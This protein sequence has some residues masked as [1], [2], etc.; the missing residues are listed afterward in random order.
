MSTIQARTKS[1]RQ[2]LDGIHYGIDYYQ[3]EYV[4]QRRHVEELLNDLAEKFED[5]YDSM[6]A[7]SQVAQY[8]HYFLGSIITVV[9]NGQHYI[10]D[11]QQRLTTLTLLFIYLHH[12]RQNNGAIRNLTQLIYA[13]KF[14]KKGFNIDVAARND[15]MQALFEAGNFDPT[16]QVDLSVRNLVDR[17]KDLQELFPETLAGPAAPY[18]VDWLIENVD[19]VEIVAQSDDDAFTIFESMNDRGVNLSQVDMLKGYLLAHINSDDARWAHQTKEKANTVWKKLTL[20]LADIEKDEE[21]TF[22]KVWLRAKYAD[23]IRQRKKGAT[24]QD[25]ENINTFHRWARDNRQRLGLY[26]TQDFYNFI[27]QK[28]RYFAE[29]YIAMRQAAQTFT[30]DREA[31]YYN[32]YNNFTLQY[33]LALAPLRL[34]DDKD[35]AQEKIR[36]VTTFADI[37]LARRMV[38]FR[39][40]GYNTLAYT[41]FNLMRDIRD[42]PVAELQAYLLDY[43]A[44]MKD[45]FKGITGDHY[46]AY[47]LNN[48]SG[49]SIRYLL[50]RITAW[51]EQKSGKHSNFLPLLTS[52]RANRSRLSISGRTTSSA[53]K[54]NSPAQPSSSATA[55]FLAG[56]SCCHAAPTK[57]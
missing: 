40:N 31:I 29:T 6:H 35:I 38:N 16:D 49:R 51:V 1:V 25:F 53:T 10:V 44:K 24:N 15:C 52:N 57:A 54:T 7:R 45:S 18:F 12:L 19:M 11:G 8:P 27:D 4:W 47:R 36:L 30:P 55:I 50:A 17:Y 56:C 46:E 37:F 22:F 43:L 48:F 14:G 3:R 13:E 39:R 26:G 42:L 20:Q 41:M 23:S 2:L 21:D 28:V 33:M 9:E 34:S 5:S 32:G